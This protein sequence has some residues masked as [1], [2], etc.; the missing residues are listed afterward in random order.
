MIELSKTSINRE[1]MNKLSAHKMLCSCCYFLFI[2]L[3][4]TSSATIKENFADS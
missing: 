1:Q 3:N 4:C 2:P